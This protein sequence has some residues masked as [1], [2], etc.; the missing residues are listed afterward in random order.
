MWDDRI[1]AGALLSKK[2]ALNSFRSLTTEYV[3]I[4]WVRACVRGMCHVAFICFCKR[5]NIMELYQFVLIHF[6]KNMNKQKFRT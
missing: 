4:E 6:E 5:H 3:W 2:G 1:A